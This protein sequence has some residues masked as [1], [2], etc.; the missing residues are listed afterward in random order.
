MA[1]ARSGSGEALWD[2]VVEAVASIAELDSSVDSSKLERRIREC[3]RKGIKGLDFMRKQWP[4]LI[5]EYADAVFL[6]LFASFG[7][8]DWLSRADF[9]LVMDA[10][11]RE[12][13]PALLLKKIQKPALERTVLAAYSRAFEEQRHQRILWEVCQVLV[14]GE[15]TRKKV[16]AALQLGLKEASCC[17]NAGKG[18]DETEDF[19]CRWID[20]T[21]AAIHKVSGDA[22]SQLPKAVA[23]KLFHDAVQAGAL[24]L[25]LGKPVSW[26]WLEEMVDDAYAAHSS[27]F[28]VKEAEAACNASLIE[29]NEAAE[30]VQASR[31]E[32]GGEEPAA[33]R[34]KQ[35]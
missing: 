11:V 2:A 21:L 18:S 10:G 12:Q 34:L 31:N 6:S 1:A 27:D 20:R 4:R 26:H 23:G 30:S 16:Y 13:F 9:L 15:K 35:N 22:E 24:P 28:E 33:K 25:A 8:K 32:T 19:A 14:Q 5:N 7:D 3:F 29:Q 17:P